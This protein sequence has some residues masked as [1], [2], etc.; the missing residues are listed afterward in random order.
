ML[1]IYV[2]K[3]ASQIVSSSTN[4]PIF[5]EQHLLC[6]LN[7]LRWGLRERQPLLFLKAKAHLKLEIS[8][9][10]YIVLHIANLRKGRFTRR[11]QI[12]FIFS[13]LSE[14]QLIVFGIDVQ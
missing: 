14:E 12:K 7:S 4:Y 13:N 10:K 5:G 8:M 2:F 6:G 1:Y 9:R 3:A 11:T